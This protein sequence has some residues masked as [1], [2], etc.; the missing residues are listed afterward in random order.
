MK[1]TVLLLFVILAGCAQIAF[2]QSRHVKGKVLD[3]KGVGLPG[4]GITI[5]NTT[6]GTVTDV[7]GKFELDVPDGDDILIVQA[8]G[9]AT[10]EATITGNAV[11]VNLKSQSKEL[12]ET[13]VTALGIKRESRTLSYA[14]QTV[15]G[16][17]MNKTGTGNPL[18]ELSGKVSGLDVINASGDPGGGTYIRLR[19]VTSLTGDNQPLIVI[20]GIPVDNSINNFD[21]TNA[22]FQAG[23]AAGNATGGSQATNRGLDINPNDIDNISVLKGPEASALYGIRGQHGV[24]L[25][26]TKKGNTAGTKGVHVNVSSSM[27]V[28]QANKLPSLQNQY[29]EGSGGKYS[30]P[31]RV[32]WG[33]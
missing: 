15:S 4:A 5:K 3:E 11:M 6:T 21:P 8:I 17:D 12:H 25:I 10:Q 18:G 2:A 13:V 16:E 32:S 27:S 23:G 9:Y 30:Y 7:D 22:G 33:A 20:D 28:D 31:N 26:T 24:I 29:S 1:K 14:T 19:G